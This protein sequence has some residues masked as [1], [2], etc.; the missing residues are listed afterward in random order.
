M[1]EKSTVSD[2]AVKD[3]Q[4]VNILLV[5]DGVYEYI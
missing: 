5:K 4:R 1:G 3:M 2:L